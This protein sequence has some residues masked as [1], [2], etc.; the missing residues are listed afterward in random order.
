M[1]QKVSNTNRKVTFLLL[2]QIVLLNFQSQS[3]IT[4][5]SGLTDIYYIRPGLGPVKVCVKR[6]YTVLMTKVYLVCSRMIRN[7]LSAD[8]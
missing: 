6:E 5:I 7:L 4:Q 8:R 2:T 1:S 3:P